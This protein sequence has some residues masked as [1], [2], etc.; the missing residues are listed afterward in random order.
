M[1]NE[2]KQLLLKDLCARLPYKVKVGDDLGRIYEL[3][4]GNAYLIDLYYENGDYVEPPIRPYLHPLSS[5]TEDED[6]EWQYYKCKIAESCDELLEKRISELHNWFCKK[7]FDYRGLIDKELA[8]L[9]PDG[10]YNTKNE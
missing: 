6:K 7:H 3:H 8:L 10:M 2:E 4:I 5:M 9:A 1:T